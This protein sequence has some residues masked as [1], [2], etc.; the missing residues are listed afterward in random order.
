MHYLFSKVG[1]SF[2]LAFVLF[3]GPGV[4]L[5]L[6]RVGLA[7]EAAEAAKMAIL[8][9][10]ALALSALMAA[11]FTLPPLALSA[12]SKRGGH[13]QGIW[14]TAFFLPWVLGESAAIAA[15]IPQLA[16]LSLPGCLRLVA[17]ALFEKPLSYDLPLWA[18]LLVLALLFVGCGYLLTH[19]VARMETL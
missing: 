11:A 7:K 8:V 3:A 16:L 6:V 5:A 4:L 10:K 9:P 2:V 1:A 13:A 19:R 15:D 17:Q 12:F 18:P 14:T